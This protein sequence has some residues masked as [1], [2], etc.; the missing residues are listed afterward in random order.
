MSY[1]DLSRYFPSRKL[2]NLVNYS[3][4]H[5]LE[6]VSDIVAF[7]DLI[8]DAHWIYNEETP[9]SV[10]IATAHNA[11]WCWDWESNVKQLVAQCEE[12]CILYLLHNLALKIS[13]LKF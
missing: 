10:A 6:A 2:D 8:W 13:F 7:S 12:L 11:V 9:T 1:V 5:S 4:L 3:S